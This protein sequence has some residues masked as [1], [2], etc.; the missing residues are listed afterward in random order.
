MK[1]SIYELY[2]NWLYHSIMLLEPESK[3]Y[4]NLL[5][6]LHDTNF[7]WLV[8]G[9]D[10]RADDGTQLRLE[11]IEH[12]KQG[13]D[14]IWLDDPCS[15]LE[16]LVAFSKKAEF[17]TDVNSSEWFWEFVG[18]LDLLAYS[19]DAF[20]FDAASDK[21][22][23]FIWRL[24]SF[25]GSGGILPLNSVVCDQRKVEIWYQFSYYLAERDFL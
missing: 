8:S 12:N 2:F 10:N 18:N 24:Y 4:F 22:Y 20:D 7:V 19:D 5:D 21:I 16:M 15:V 11:F 23:N 6:L 17:Q 3:S 1:E 25:D 13:V 14:Q 9:D